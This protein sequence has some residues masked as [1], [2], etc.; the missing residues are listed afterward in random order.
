MPG[1]LGKKLVFKDTTVVQ[2]TPAGCVAPQPKGLPNAVAVACKP[3]TVVLCK[4]RRAFCTDDEWC[5]AGKRPRKVLASW[6]TSRSV[7]DSEKFY[8]RAYPKTKT[9]AILC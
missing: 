6:A 2:S 5:M 4:C 7:L 3:I 9:K 1:L 8:A